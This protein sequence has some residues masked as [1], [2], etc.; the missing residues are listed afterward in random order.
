MAEKYFD[1]GL[2]KKASTEYVDSFR[3][4][5]EMTK[6]AIKTL[7]DYPSA[8]TEGKKVYVKEKEYLGM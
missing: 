1:N 6:E 7:P 3:K 5:G 2:V 4:V 8:E